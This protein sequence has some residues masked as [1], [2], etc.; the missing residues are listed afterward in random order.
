VFVQAGVISETKMTLMTQVSSI[1]LP[2]CTATCWLLSPTALIRGQSTLEFLTTY[3]VPDRLRISASNYTQ[4]L[5]TSRARRSSSTRSKM[6][7]NSP[8]L[9]TSTSSSLVSF[10]R[11]ADS[12]PRGRQDHQQAP[13]SSSGVSAGPPTGPA[14]SAAQLRSLLQAV[15]TEVFEDSDLLDEDGP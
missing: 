14:R 8:P 9:R 5:P 12:E 6:K 10:V 15:L 4:P 11:R 2:N 1:S 13:E 3:R 7:S